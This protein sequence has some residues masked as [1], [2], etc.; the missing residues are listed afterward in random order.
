M[1]NIEKVRYIVNEHGVVID[2]IKPSEQ[3]VKLQQGDRVFRKSASD[4]LK[5]AKEIKYSFIKINPRIY[6]YCRKYST[7]QTLICHIGYMDNILQFDNGKLI[8]MKNMSKLCGVSN[9]TIRRQVQGM[10]ADDILH[11]IKENKT[12][13][14]ILN[15]WLCMRGKRIDTKTYNE[16]C[17]SD[18]RNKTERI[19]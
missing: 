9:S 5:N 6:E 17:M 13:Y 19:N 4:Y 14:F 7:L 3:Y 11:K 16:F 18:I 2:E 1:V 12:T 10:I 8:T 15:P